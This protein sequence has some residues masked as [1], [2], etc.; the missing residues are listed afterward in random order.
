MQW[1]L[2]S[3][4]IHGSILKDLVILKDLNAAFIKYVI[5]SGTVISLN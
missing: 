1:Y 4:E 2:H 5:V 3:P